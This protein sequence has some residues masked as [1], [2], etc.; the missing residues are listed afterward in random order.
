MSKVEIEREGQR[1][2][3]RARWGWLIVLASVLV[4]AGAW[5]LWPRPP[6]TNSA[7][8]LSQEVRMECEET[9]KSWDER[10]GVIEAELRGI[11]GQLSD[12]VRISSPFADGR[13]T[14][15]MEDGAEWAR[16]IERINR[17]K[18]EVVKGR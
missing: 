17:E 3:R 16:T 11:P 13:A 14:G 4:L 15:V 7:A 6:D 1:P 9:G 12:T 10:R 8:F 2:A 5:R 18:R